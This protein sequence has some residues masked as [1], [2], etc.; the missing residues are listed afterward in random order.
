[1]RQADTTFPKR[2]CANA[3]LEC[4]AITD[5]LIR[6]HLSQW[7]SS[8]RWG[9]ELTKPL[10]H[11]TVKFQLFPDIYGISDITANALSII[12]VQ[13]YRFHVLIYHIFWELQVAELQNALQQ[14]RWSKLPGL[15]PVSGS[16]MATPS[17]RKLHTAVN[18]N[19]TQRWISTLH[20]DISTLSAIS[21]RDTVSDKP[22]PYWRGCRFC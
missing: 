5:W 18:I 1:M 4:K 7:S 17:I 9:K 6:K 10:N 15:D 3:N 12:K 19:S 2:Y 16:A 22:S 14:V 11:S 20:Y 8:L 13:E 21:N